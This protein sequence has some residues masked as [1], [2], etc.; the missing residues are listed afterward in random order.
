MIHLNNIC[1]VLF[2]DFIRP[3]QRF[4][5]FFILE[6]CVCD[7]FEF[8]P[9]HRVG[10]RCSTARHFQLACKNVKWCIIICKESGFRA[11]ERTG[12]STIKG[13]QCA[14]MW[15]FFRI[16]SITGEF[17][18][19][20]EDHSMAHRI[21]LCVEKEVIEISFVKNMFFNRFQAFCSQMSGYGRP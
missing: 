7:A 8:H 11:C 19:T 14:W 4:L 20:I 2:F 6:I 18:R 13:S 12:L 16:K 9:S 17:H 5:A 3:Q 10:L 21:Y 1:S 15:P